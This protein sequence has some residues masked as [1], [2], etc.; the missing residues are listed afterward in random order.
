M[1]RWVWFVPLGV[2]V[3]AGA[4]QAFRLGWIAANMTETAAIE[5]YAAR[6]VQ[7]TGDPAAHCSARPGADV[8]LVVRCGQGRSAWEYHVNRFGGLR[9]AYG[10]GATPDR[11]SREGEPR[12]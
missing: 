11:M 7:Q 1:P 9:E 2:V 4:L 12:T 6:Y 10:P 3:S 8:W 5:A